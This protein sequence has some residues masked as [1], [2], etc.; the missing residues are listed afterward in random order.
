IVLATV[1]G[2]VHDIGKNLV[3]IILSNNGY[4]VVNIGIKQPITAILDAAESHSAD[5]IGMSGLLVKSTVIMKENLEEMNTRGVAQRWPVLLGGA[6]L[7]RAYVEDDLRALYTGQVHYARD[8]FEGLALMDRV[9]S[10]KRGGG[11]AVDAGREAALAARRTRR[12]RHR[13]MVAED[14]P[15]LDDSSVRSDVAGDVAVPRAP[16]LGTRV[17]K[18]IPL[19][20]YASMLDERATFL[21]QWG[22]R[23]SRGGGGPSYEE[24]AETE[25]RPRLRYWLDRLVSDQV[26]EAAVVYGYFPCYSEGNTVVVLDENGHAE[27]ARFEFPR[28]RR[29]RRLCIADFFRPSTPDGGRDVIAFQLVTV[30]QPVSEYTA[31]LFARNAYRDYLEVHGLSVQLTEALAE[32]WHRRVRSELALPDGSTVADDDPADLAGVLRTEY[33]GCRY[34][35]GYPACPD[36]EDRAKVAALLD[37]ER[38]GVTLS[39]EFQLHP[40]QSTDALIVHHPEANYFNAK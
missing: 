20:D 24:L 12:E 1:K 25:G 3:D 23:G 5:A 32:Y 18:G 19:G 22:L 36:L 11:A 15:D 29:D 34:S 2:D 30:G 33:R 7:T 28:Q 37:A 39:E 35:F 27:R 26:L 40:E 9:M 14:L 38:V 16:F 21:G 4:E 8:A 10:A 17:V 31:K 13:A 6:A